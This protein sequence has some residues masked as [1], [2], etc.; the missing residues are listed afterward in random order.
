MLCIISTSRN[1]DCR[2]SVSR[3]SRESC[4]LSGLNSMYYIPYIES[5]IAQS[6]YVYALIMHRS[7][8]SIFATQR[9]IRNSVGKIVTQN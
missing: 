2:Q 3:N 4:V 7:K 8:V 6:T 9:N 1:R 5:A